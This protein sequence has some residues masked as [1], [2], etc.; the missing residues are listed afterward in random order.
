MP[1]GPFRNEAEQN[2]AFMNSDVGKE[3]TR[4]ML[5]GQVVDQIF[6][7]HGSRGL[8]TLGI[9]YQFEGVSQYMVNQELK[10]KPGE[11]QEAY[12][13]RF[14]QHK[15]DYESLSLRGAPGASALVVPTRDS[16]DPATVEQW[17]QTAA[18]WLQPREGEIPIDWADRITDQ[19]NL[20]AE[21]VAA[22]G[23]VYF[24]GGTEHWGRNRKNVRDPV[25]VE[26]TWEEVAESEAAHRRAG[27]IGLLASAIG[28][29]IIGA[30]GFSAVRRHRPLPHHF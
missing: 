21:D 16:G 22:L 29:T 24:P 26:Q 30:I 8:Q 2:D 1:Y 15:T 13:A 12:D 25:M 5:T 23:Q 27:K 19:S 4:E 10:R 11:S 18:E 17:K 9:P 3:F 28:V 14:E 7:Q 20:S 6:E